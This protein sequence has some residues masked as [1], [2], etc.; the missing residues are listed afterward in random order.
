MSTVYY[1]KGCKIG[2]KADK[3]DCAKKDCCNCRHYGE[4][5][6]DCMSCF[7]NVSCNNSKCELS[8]CYEKVR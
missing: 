2:K 6:R 8:G 5:L 4:V 1:D 7:G 3:S